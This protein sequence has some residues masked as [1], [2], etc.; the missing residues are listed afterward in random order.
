MKHKHHIIPKH[1]GGNDEPENIVEFTIEEHAEAHKKLYEEHGH[2]QDLIA[3]KGL[4]G[5]LTSDECSFIAIN[6]GAKKGAELTNALR[7]A[8]HTKKERKYPLGTD[9]RKIRAQRYWFNNGDKEGQFSLNDHPDGWQRGR[10]KSVM[11]KT[12]PHVSL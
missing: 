4:L 10:L 11:K 6:E 3:W 7:W 5:L 12:N 8:N 1:M 9:G 2:W